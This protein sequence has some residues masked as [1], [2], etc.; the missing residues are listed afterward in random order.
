MGRLDDKA[1]LVTG[2][3]GLLG[4]AFSH[5]LAAEGARVLVNDV[6]GSR[7]EAVATAIA[8][9]GGLASAFQ[10][11]VDSW[12]RAGRIV[13]TCVDRFGRIDCLVNSAHTTTALPLVE[14]DEDRFRTTMESH[15]TG[16]FACAHHAA[17]HMI[18][19]GGGSIV[20]LIS[21]AM[22]GLRGFSAYG[23]A[24]GAILS[25]TFSWA[26]EL[27]THGIRVNAVSPAAR[28]RE[29]GEPVS[30]RMP[31][32]RKP[33]QSVDEM[34]AQTPSPESVAPLVVFLASDASDWISGQAMFL[35]GDS[36]ALIRHPK[37]DRFAFSPEGW[38]VD[39][40]DRHFHDCFA[41]ALERPS[42]QAT[43]YA[44][45]EGVGHRPKP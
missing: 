15:V 1:V 45:H 42:M 14:L 33:G 43:P 12:D 36:L 38:S 24:K 30:H 18:E 16:H 22:Q 35:A 17:Q 21:R 2:G 41:T 44:W 39:D 37:E 9:S 13:E 5:A 40:L 19:Q 11:S 4:A 7:A 10:G 28:R 32:R 8:E 34:R 3:G 27:A 20:N 29:P 31:W 25:A 23:A 6:D 26:L